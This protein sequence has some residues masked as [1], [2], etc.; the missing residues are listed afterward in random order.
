MARDGVFLEVFRN[1]VQA[2]IDET[3]SVI[4]R[5][6]YTVF[7]K[8]TQDFGA[9]LFTPEGEVFAMPLKVAVALGVGMPCRAVVE[10]IE[11]WQEGD[12]VVTNDP[13]ST[14]GMVTHLADIYLV[15]PIFAGGQLLCFVSTFIHFSDV[16]GKVPGSVTP[17]CYDVYQ[18]GLRLRPIKLVE[19]GQLNQQLLDLILDNCRIPDQNWGD[20]RAMFAGLNTAERRVHE[21]VD[22]Y[23]L[24]AVSKGIGQ[25]LDY[26]ERRSREL[27]REIPDGTYEAW[28]YMESDGFSDR[29]IRI[30][31]RMTVQGDELHLDF[32]GTDHQVRGAINMPSFNAPGHFMLSPTIT[33]FFHTLDPGLPYNSGL[34]RPMRQ[35]I[36]TGNLLNPEAGAACGVRAATMNRV[37]DVTLATL[38][39]ASPDKLPVAGAGQVCIVLLSTLDVKTGVRKVGVVQPITGGSGARPW[40]DGI[41]G[42]DFG[43][44][45]LRNIPSETIETEMPIL[46]ERYGLRPDS[47]GVGQYRGGCGNELRIRVFAPETILTARGQERSRFRPW[48]RLGGFPGSLGIAIVNQDTPGERRIHM[49]D[50]LLLNSQDTVTFRSQGGGGFGSPLER[51][52]DAVLSD[53]SAGLV[54]AEVARDNYGVIVV[55]GRVD[56]D[57]TERL[58]ASL[59]DEARFSVQAFNYGDERAAFEE[60]WGDA[61]YSAL[62][63]AI[64]AYPVALRWI[65]KQAVMKAVEEKGGERPRA[66]ASDVRELTR[67]LVQTFAGAGES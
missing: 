52:S 58:R 49:I 9:V 65:L 40:K 43:G 16:G 53:V 15:K 12:V 23:G 45:F 28:D 21:L 33:R 59:R 39:Q 8:E 18:E 38:S 31:L 62:I 27:I 60:T 10:A 44:G 2:I 37:L 7:V 6:G 22:R 11:N 54:S 32:T 36:P 66:V 20:F 25:V 30:R 26:A 41:D 56:E 34:V 64:A 24:D 3:A 13:Y 35:Q 29:P 48:G 1:R 14:K 19:R 67:A 42:N 4:F 61:A 46:V 51:R 50:E 55:D 17:A 63:E 57:A 47:G 5:T